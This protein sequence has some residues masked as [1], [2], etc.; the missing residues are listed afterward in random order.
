MKLQPSQQ[1]TTVNLYSSELP[2]ATTGTETLA[3]L[4]EQ[5]A[6]KQSYMIVSCCTGQLL[7][8]LTLLV[9][10]SCETEYRRG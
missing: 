8:L 10:P 3:E 4:S 6:L 2:D 5:V 7:E 1:P 9:S